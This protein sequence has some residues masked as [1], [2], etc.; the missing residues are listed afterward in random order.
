MRI[1]FLMAM[2]LQAGVICSHRV[3]ILVL[4]RITYI[5]FA[6]SINGGGNSDPTHEGLNLSSIGQSPEAELLRI[7]LMKY[8]RVL[9]LFLECFRK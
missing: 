4:D 8:D 6:H 5:S 3:L 2:K 7:L 1:H 9:C